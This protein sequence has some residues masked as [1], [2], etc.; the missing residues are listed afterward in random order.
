LN[1]S[2]NANYHGNKIKEGEMDRTCSMHGSDERW[3]KI[4][5]SENLKEKKP[6]RRFGV[7]RGVILRCTLEKEG[8][9]FRAGFIWRRIR[10]SGGLL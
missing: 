8:L 3:V 10:S 2:P 5:W 4:F 1:S 9:R 7:E 6:L